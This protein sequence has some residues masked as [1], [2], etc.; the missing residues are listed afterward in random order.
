EGAASSGSRYVRAGV[1][2]TVRRTRRRPAGRCL[3]G[4]PVGPARTLPFCGA[5]AG[6]PTGQ[7]CSRLLA[8]R[9]VVRRAVLLAEQPV[10]LDQEGTVAAADGLLLH[11]EQ[12]ADLDAGPAVVEDQADHLALLR[13]QVLHLAVERAPPLQLLLVLRRGGRL[14]GGRAGAVVG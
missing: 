6:R 11:L 3:Q 5:T 7:P 4:R 14:P 12:R 8:P 10:Q 9:W 2:Q 13:R 1:L